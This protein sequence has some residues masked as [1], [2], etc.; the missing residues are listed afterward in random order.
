MRVTLFVVED[1]ENEPEIFATTTEAYDYMS[2]ESIAYGE[3]YNFDDKEIDE[4][5]EELDRNSLSSET[6]GFFS[7]YL[8]ERTISCY[9]RTIDL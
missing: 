4:C 6:T 9:E 8:G 2:E 5:L 7:T 3:K 1:S